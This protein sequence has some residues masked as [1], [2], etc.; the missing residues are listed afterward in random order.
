MINT[1]LVLNRYLVPSCIKL[2][3][4]S[5]ILVWLYPNI[6]RSKFYQQNKVLHSL[7]SFCK[8]SFCK[9]RHTYYPFPL[10]IP[11]KEDAN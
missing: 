2:P 10:N 3:S 5:E 6:N 7:I 11:I 9:E 4:F 8:E 1:A